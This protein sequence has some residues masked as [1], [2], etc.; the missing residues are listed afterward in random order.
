MEAAA[1]SIPAQARRALPD[2]GEPVPR[3]ALPTVGIFLGALAVW[4]LATWA[5]LGH[6]APPWVTIPAAAAVSFVMFTV[7]HDATHYSISRTRWVNALFGRMSVPFVASYVS[8]PVLGYIHIEHHRNTNEHGGTEPGA[9]PDGFA[10]AGPGW[11]TPFRWLTI[12]LWYAVFYLKRRPTRPVA[13]SA[14]AGVLGVLTLAGIGAA[15]A[16][17]NLWTVALVYLIPQRIAVG[18]LGWW[19]DWLPHHGLEQTQRENRYRA[20]RARVGME[21][22]FTPA[23]LSQNY[24][25]IHHLHPSIPFYRYLTAWRRNEEAYLERD[26]AIATVFG[27]QLTPEEYRVW[28][29]L[30]SAL[31]RMRRVKVPEG[32]S[33]SH[34]VFHR[35][36]VADVRRL[37]KD[38]VLIDFDVPE[39]LRELFSFRPGQHLTVRTDLGGEGVRR[40]YSICCPATD[41]SLRIAVKLIPGGAF[42]SFAMEQLKAGDEL[43]L[44]TPTGHFSIKPDPDNIKHYVGITAGSGITPILSILTTALQVEADSYFTLIYGNRTRDSTMFRE[45]LDQ[46]ESRYADR[47]EILHVLSR[48]PHRNPLLTGRID[49]EKIE[50]LL[51]TK[52]PPDEIDEWFLC[53]PLELT[54]VVRETLIERRADPEHVH[55]ELFHGYEDTNGTSPARANAAPC[56]VTIRLSGREESF[57]L[58]GGDSLLEGALRVRPDAPYACMGGACGTCRARLLEG[59]VQM[60]HNFALGQDDVERDYV[61]TCQSHPTSPAVSVDYDG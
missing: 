6:H 8:F 14:E 57:E 3:L 4:G 11:Q 59:T 28:R 16:T 30:D 7:A 47:F 51:A 46:L 42:S 55:M 25:L 35:L 33:A 39:G 48:E 20:T 2:P 19:F 15:A 23:M 52:L 45:E 31:A 34:A 38:S 1:A 32:S 24:H 18:T 27:H 44:M 37:T 60:D 26:A 43:E 22:L 29:E 12:D 41:G 58:T 10:T 56:S 50:T 49:R 61:L 9:D 36:P 54:A 53:G 13:E 5:A 17:G 40:N 21:W